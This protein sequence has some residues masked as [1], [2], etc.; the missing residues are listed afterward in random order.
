MSLLEVT[1]LVAG[2]GDNAAVHEVD[3]DVEA[4]E[5]VAILGPNGAGKTTLLSTIIGFIRP[6][7]GSVR[8]DGHDLRDTPP[9]RRIRAGM[10]LVPEG[11]GI[12]SGLTVADNLRLVRRGDRSIVDLF[13]ELHDKLN[14]RAGLLSGG[15]QQMVA[16]ARSLAT[17]PRLLFVDELSLGL[18]P[19][20]VDRLL[21]RLR[22]AAADRDLAVVLVEQHVRQALH[23]ANRAYVLSLGRVTM[24]ETAQSLLANRAALEASYLGGSS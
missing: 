5:I 23:T 15:E 2:Y 14:R 9:H 3:I 13:P 24:E 20:V 6:M 11:R 21:E 4:G 12:V 17:R 22:E 7:A 10:A 1:G 19:R 18:A 16:L 8:F